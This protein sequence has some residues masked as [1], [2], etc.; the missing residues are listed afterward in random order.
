MGLA[1]PEATGQAQLAAGAEGLDSPSAGGDRSSE[2]ALLLAS[3][4][5]SH[6]DAR[7]PAE[8]DRQRTHF[9]LRSQGWGGRDV[10]E[11]P[12]QEEGPG[13]SGGPG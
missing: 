1:D 8:P 11:D 3:L 10:S 7:F 6:P 4:V 12:G 5:D 2:A 13:V 9:A